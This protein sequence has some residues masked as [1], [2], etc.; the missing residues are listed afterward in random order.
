[1]NG[2]QA[3]DRP[4]DPPTN[5]NTT[6]ATSANAESAAPAIIVRGVVKTYKAKRSRRQ[7][8]PA[9]TALAGVGFELHAGGMLALLGP[10]GAG[11]S[12]LLRIL[13]TLDLPDEG[14]VRLMGQSLPGRSGPNS[15]IN[16]NSNSSNS[17]NNN[18]LRSIRAMLGVVFQ[19]VSLDPLLTIRENLLIHAATHSMIGRAAA[20]AVEHAARTLC[21]H[22]RLDDRV[23]VLSGGLA[24]RADLARALLHNPSLVLLDEPTGGLDPNARRRFLDALDNLRA[25][26]P[27][28]SILLS[29]HLIDEAERCDRVVL[30]HEG[31]VVGDGTPGSLRSNL[32]PAVVRCRAETDETR[33]V[34]SAAAKQH[35]NIDSEHII[36]RG[37]VIV[38]ELTNAGE[39]GTNS[40]NINATSNNTA[41]MNATSIGDFAA[42]L[43]AASIAFEIA[44]PTLDDVFANL[45]GGRS[46]E[47]DANFTNTDNA[48]HPNTN[49]AQS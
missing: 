4:S 38:I 48:D 18:I 16:T 37:G 6:T 10:N 26:R 7:P 19:T 41:S 42:A 12:T 3:I 47:H 23:G 17:K 8:A 13:A 29:T 9:R 5:F 27:E 11:K 20:D 24:R 43:A 36:Q 49:E 22:D 35:L 46:I 30:L 32:G 25:A 31:R 15:D 33:R 14:E 2:P 39:L 21:V 28:V 40:P 45:T 44:P 34:V 1:M